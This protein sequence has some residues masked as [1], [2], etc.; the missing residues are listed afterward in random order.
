MII[1]DLNSL[2]QRLPP[3]PAVLAP[4]DVWP[5]DWVQCFEVC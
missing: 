5:D 1:P 2:A 4:H 3:M